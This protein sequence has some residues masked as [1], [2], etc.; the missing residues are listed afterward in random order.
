MAILKMTRAARHIT[1]D[2]DGD[3]IGNL[4]A[5]AATN[6]NS[7]SVRAACRAHVDR[8]SGV[9]H[10]PPHPAGHIFKMIMMTVGV[11]AFWPASLA[12][13]S[14]SKSEVPSSR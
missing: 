8:R 7:M 11:L 14:L 10:R 5:W 1:H 4:L 2:D 13:A 6:S 3:L 9:E 12:R